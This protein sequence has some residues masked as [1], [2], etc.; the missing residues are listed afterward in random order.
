MYSILNLLGKYN[1]SNLD[2]LF[3]D[4]EGYD[5]DILID[6][7]NNSKQEPIIIFEY[8]HI[9]N[10]ILKNLINKIISRNYS[11]FDINENLICLPNKI[12]KFL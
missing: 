8:V 5:G 9:K 12:E 7:L 11:Y 4:A 6:F 1:I 2:L 10:N 3:I